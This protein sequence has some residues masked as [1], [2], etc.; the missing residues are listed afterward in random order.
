MKHAVLLLVFVS[1]ASCSSS[2][3]EL[4]GLATE[5]VPK[6]G[7]TQVAV[8]TE[9]SMR[10]HGE[11]DPSSVKMQE[12]DGVCENVSVQVSSDDFKTCVGGST[13]VMDD[14]KH[15]VIIDLPSALETERV[16]TVSFDDFSFMFS[17][18]PRAE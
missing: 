4:A 6:D 16:Y 14:D 9:I 5:T 12:K 11:V 13:E 2:D 18:A 8:D 1:F 10:F 3:S 17:T 15:K 7:A